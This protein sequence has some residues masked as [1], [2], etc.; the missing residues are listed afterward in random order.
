[1]HP[2]AYI[3]TCPSI[4]PSI[5]HSF[6]QSSIHP[7]PYSLTHLPILP[8]THPF[9]CFF[10]YPPA[11]PSVHISTHTFTYSLIYPPICPSMHPSPTN[12]FSIHLPIHPPTRP[13]TN[14]STHYP[15]LHESCPL[16]PSYIH[17]HTYSYTHMYNMSSS[18]TLQVIMTSCYV[19]PD[20]LVFC[21][22]NF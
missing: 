18:A 14:L 16:F 1:M 19:T 5:I 3:T 20:I 11:Y 7:P 12:P 13:L 2:S 10:I 22:Y 17:T 6:I 15:R 9:T 21:G 8:H 4:C